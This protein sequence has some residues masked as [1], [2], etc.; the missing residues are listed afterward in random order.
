M[1]SK[2]AEVLCILF[3]SSFWCE[4]IVE[5]MLVESRMLHE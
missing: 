2:M 1:L 3:D 5:D 4:F